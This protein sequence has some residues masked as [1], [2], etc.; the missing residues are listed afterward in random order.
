M[1]TIEKKATPKPT[2]GQVFKTYFHCDDPVQHA[3]NLTHCWLSVLS[4]L[5]H[6]EGGFMSPGHI[7][8]LSEHFLSVSSMATDRN[9][10]V[11]DPGA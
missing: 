7:Q 3:H 8:L 4:N 5:D 11:D 10:S 6:Q 2:I 1:S 9:A